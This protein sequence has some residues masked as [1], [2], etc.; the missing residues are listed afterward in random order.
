M[1]VALRFLTDELG[2]ENDDDCR[3]FIN[4]QAEKDLI[5]EKTDANNVVQLRVRIKEGAGKFD[6]KRQA[7]FKT[8]DIKGQI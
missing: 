2:F 3:Q 6:A 1:S 8:V 5:D 7:A 4:E